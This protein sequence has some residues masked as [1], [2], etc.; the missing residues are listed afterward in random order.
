MIA[1][2]TYA[3]KKYFYC[4]QSVLRHIT[5]A[6]SHHKEAHFILATDTSKEAKEA[7]EVA[8][9]ELP[10]GWKI[11]SINIEVNDSEGEKYKE[12]SQML[13]AALQ[14]AAFSLARKIRATSLWSVESDMLVSAESLR[15]A[16]WTLQ[17]PQAD[18]S[19]YYD[20]AAVT[21]PNGL[22]LGGFGTPQSPINEDF[23]VEERKV[24]ERLKKA[25][26]ACESR[27]K[28]CKDKEISEK[29]MKRMGRLREKIKARPPD[30]NIWEVTA[31]HGW[32]RRG[33]M[34][35]AYPAIGRGSIVPSD[36]CGLGCTLLSQKAL[37]L[38]TFEGYDGKGTQ[39]LFLCWH[40]WYP[41][42]IRIACVPHA[43]CDH[44]KLKSKDAPE[45][46]P[47]IIHYRAYHETEKEYRGHLRFKSQPWIF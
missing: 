14:G 29:E 6:A 15:V 45:D 46:T 41:A 2:A 44:V 25:I 18:G 37:S 7:L 40:K 3:T 16:E 5:A 4:W 11:A 13:I 30:G 36:W 22:F 33:W 8:R 35:F 10:E 43:V 19:P 27:L 31:K 34:D 23:T 20:V 26:A 39:D 42:G 12:Q 24:P 9:H 28:E 47:S 21:Y 17:M 32:R 38:A 1:I